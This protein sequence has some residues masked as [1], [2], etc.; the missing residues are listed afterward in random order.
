MKR[1]TTLLL[2]IMLLTLVAC[3]SNNTPAPQNNSGNAGNLNFSQIMAGNGSTEYVWGLQDEAT[4]E[5][6]IAAGL[7][8]N[9]EITFSADGT[10]TMVEEDGS[11]IIQHPD[12]TWSLQSS[13]GEIG[14]VGGS[15]PDNEFT[16]LVPAPELEIL[17][18]QMDEDTFVAAFTSATMEEIKAYALELKVSGFNLNIEEVEVDDEGYIVYS[19]YG[20]NSQGYGVDVI[21]VNI[22]GSSGITITAPTN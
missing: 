15:W 1:L 3:D 19:Y 8:N 18:I 21:Y 22:G 5:E 17:A 11:I 10:M 20:E 9:I 13:E 2:A 16:R 7:E 14:Q 6:L 4:K 12:G